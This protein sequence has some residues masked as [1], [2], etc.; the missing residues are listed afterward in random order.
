MTWPQCIE[1]VPQCFLVVLTLNNTNNKKNV[2]FKDHRAHVVVFFFTLDIINISRM[3]SGCGGGGG[4][5]VDGGG[6]WGRNKK[7]ITPSTT[8]TFYTKRA[9]T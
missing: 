6:G 2:F 3:T 9:R 1:N 7:N 5:G 4:R 8:K